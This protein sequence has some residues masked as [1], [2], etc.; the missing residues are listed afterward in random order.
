MLDLDAMRKR[1]NRYRPDR[2]KRRKVLRMLLKSILG[3]AFLIS[4]VVCMSAA[5]AHAYYALLEAPWLRVEDLQITGLKHA[6]RKH[7]LDAL[8]VPR[9]ANLLTLKTAELSRRL[10]SIPWLESSVVRI[11]PPGRIVVEVQ[12]REP[13]AIIQADDLLL[14][15][16]KGILFSRTAREKHPDLLFVT[17]FQ[18]M[19]LQVGTT[20]P[21]EPLEE[22]KEMCTA[23]AK[24]KD[25][26]P[27][28]LISECRWLGEAGFTLYTPQRTIAIQMGSEDFEEKLVRLKGIFAMLRENQWL[29]SVTRIDLDYPNRAYVE[30][31]FPPQK[32]T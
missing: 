8:R 23:L 4:F 30:R 27:T 9:Y 13:L 2:V 18:A 16:R 5:L 26:L 15:D 17:G 21:D 3:F 32:D 11:E 7:I 22:L 14:V 29:D 6:E 12:E 31:H 19:E 28:S 1:E 25:W 24:F 20:L 10:E